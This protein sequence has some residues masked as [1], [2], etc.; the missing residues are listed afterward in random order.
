MKV[1][2]LFFATLFAGYHFLKEDNGKAGAAATSKVD[3]PSWFQPERW[4]AATRSRNLE[5]LR[6]AKKQIDAF[7]ANPPCFT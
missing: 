4:D 5:E 7:I 6:S 2:L 3:L 1:F